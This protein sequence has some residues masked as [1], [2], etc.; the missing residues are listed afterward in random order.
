LH[1][2][3]A[4][5][6]KFPPDP[7]AAAPS[8][9]IPLS[10]AASRHYGLGLAVVT[11]GAVFFSLITTFSKFTYEAGATP[12]ALVW[13]RIAAF[14]VVIGL[15]QFAKGSSFRLPRRTMTASLPM[16][17]GM[18]M[19]SVGYL[20]SVLYIKISLAVILLYSFP[21]MAGLLAAISGRER[22]AAL[23]AF[24]LLLAF[25]GLVLAIGPERSTLDW[26][27][28]VLALTAALGMAATITFGGP[29][30][31]DVDGLTVNF[32][33]NIW[34]L[35][36]LTAYV[37]IFGGASLPVGTAGWAALGA[38]TVCY[39]LGYVGFFAAIKLLPPTQTAV[40]MNVEPL[41]SFLVAI[42]ILHETTSGMQVLG[43]AIM[44]S[45]LCFSALRGAKAES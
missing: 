31:Q 18:M 44:L 29:Y 40:M 43:I 19:M 21:L 41:C 14:I 23:K 45:A 17:V 3:P 34:M 1:S 20:S 32:W 36:A 25:V 7:G 26:R 37:A 9:R 42:F 2:Q 10:S 11:F 15:V 24:A 27:G 38:A 16:A 12:L 8:R 6:L 35:I 5:Q 39:I 22:I 30:L 13:L 4:F 28:V 33:V